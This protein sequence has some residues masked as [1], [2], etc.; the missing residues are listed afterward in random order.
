MKSVRNRYPDVDQ[1]KLDR[2]RELM[3]ANVLDALVTGYEPLIDGLKLPDEGDRH[4][5]AAAI[6]SG[7]DVIV[8]YNTK[9]FPKEAL[10]PFG[11]HPEH[12]DEFVLHLIDLDCATV[13][14]AAKEH[15][16]RL[17]NPIKSVSEYLASLQ[18]N[19]LPRSVAALERYQDLL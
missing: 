5:L 15:R 4:V 18:R 8:T 7:A 19:E 10:A 9:D 17:K 1:A 16:A 12:P 2:T 3:D 11:V 13:C 14:G 6:R